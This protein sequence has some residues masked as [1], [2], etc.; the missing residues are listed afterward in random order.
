MRRVSGGE[1]DRTNPM[2]IS[3]KSYRRFFEEAREMLF[4]AD[5]EGRLLAVNP[6]GAGLL[7]YASPQELLAVGSIHQLSYYPQDEKDFRKRIEQE[8]LIRNYELTL[9]KKD[10]GK[11][12]V[13]LTGNAIRDGGGEVVGYEG[14][15]RDF[16]ERK[17]LEKQLLHLERLAAMGKL[18]AELA[19]EIN[20]PL[21]GILMYAKLA[22][23][24]LPEGD[25]QA[26]RLE[27]ISRLATRCRM[28][29]RGLL[30]FG[31]SDTAEREWVDI[32]QTILDMFDLIRD[33]ILFRPV[34]VEMKLGENLPRVWGNR[35][36]LEQVALNMMINAAEAMEGQGTLTIE[37]GYSKEESNFSMYFKDTG[38]GISKKNLN[39]I[40]EP[41]F[42]T[43]KRGKGT[44]LG[45][46]ISHG[47]I[48]KHGGSIQINSI[49]GEDTTFVIQL[50]AGKDNHENAR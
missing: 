34:R 47:I 1:L 2:E 19:H 15:V 5:R 20:N 31:R 50:P 29:V 14:I 39:K 37:T 48:Q 17:R 18:S 23:E 30:D 11:I 12:S 10:G 21:G 41:F 27:K 4:I 36:N 26:Q 42:T 8:G 32:N 43:K 13:F 3:D 33:H 25:A 6:Y 9:R 38:P 16:S 24:D 49:P 28:I 46:S 22:L 35:S 44:G 7:G 40:F 45:L